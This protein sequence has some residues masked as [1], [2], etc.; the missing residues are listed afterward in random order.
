[1]QIIWKHVIVETP[2]YT[3]DVNHVNHFLPEKCVTRPSI[4]N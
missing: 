4:F 1:M 3:R 2:W